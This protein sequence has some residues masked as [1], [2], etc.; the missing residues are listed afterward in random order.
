M[1]FLAIELQIWRIIHWKSAFTSIQENNLP[2]EF[3]SPS[4]LLYNCVTLSFN[5]KY[6]KVQLG[7]K[8][9]GKKIFHLIISNKWF[10]MTIYSQC[11]TILSHTSQNRSKGVGRHKLWGHHLLTFGSNFLIIIWKFLIVLTVTIYFISS[12][13]GVQRTAFTVQNIIIFSNWD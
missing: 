1:K 10:T 7:Y 3:K 12:L 4:T 5:I 9:D 2:T 13:L 8:I 11:T 6:R